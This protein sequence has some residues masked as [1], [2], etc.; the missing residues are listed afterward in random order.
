LWPD[1][2]LALLERTAG[3]LQ[4]QWDANAANLKDILESGE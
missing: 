2:S 1:L 4:R 3:W